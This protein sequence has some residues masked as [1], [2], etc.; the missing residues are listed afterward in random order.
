MAWPKKSSLPTV[1]W[2]N[3]VAERRIFDK[4]DSRGNLNVNVSK[5]SGESVFLTTFVAAF[6]SPES[7]GKIC[8]F[9]YGSLLPFASA[10]L[11]DDAATTVTVSSRDS[12]SYKRLRRSWP[13]PFGPRDVGAGMS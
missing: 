11:S 3:T 2:S 9:T 1:S 4:I 5:N 8:N 7:S 13:R 10:A 6:N 12:E